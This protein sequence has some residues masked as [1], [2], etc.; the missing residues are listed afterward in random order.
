MNICE[1]EGVIEDVSCVEGVLIDVSGCA[2][3]MC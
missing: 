3:R 1:S 2:D